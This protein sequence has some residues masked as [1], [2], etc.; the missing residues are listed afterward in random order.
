MEQKTGYKKEQETIS[1]RYKDIINL[2]HHRSTKRPGMK[3]EDRAAQFSP[4]AALTGYDAVVTE[5]ARLTESRIELDE[6]EREGIFLV[7]GRIEEKLERENAEPV[8]I[9][10]TYFKPDEKKEGGAYLTLEGSV[11]KLDKHNHRLIFH[12]IEEHE[13]MEIPMEDIVELTL[14]EK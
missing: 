3:I 11:K 9:C 2:P 13:M 4:F 14:L 10:V 6:C 12:E 1:E 5:T 8:N 7:L